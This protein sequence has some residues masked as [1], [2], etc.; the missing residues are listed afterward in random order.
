ME[1]LEQI[2]SALEISPSGVLSNIDIWKVRDKSILPYEVTKTKG[3]GFTGVLSP[4]ETLLLKKFRSIK[5][6]KLRRFVLSQ[7][8]AIVMADKEL[9]KKE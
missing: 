1:R 4:D 6:E 2:S 8:R 5:N 7:I 3:D 9:N